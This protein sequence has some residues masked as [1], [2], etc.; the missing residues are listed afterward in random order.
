MVLLLE[1]REFR[2]ANSVYEIVKK[3]KIVPC[4]VDKRETF[5]E[6]LIKRGVIIE[7]NGL[8]KIEQNKLFFDF[9]ESNV[10][11]KIESI[12]KDNSYVTPW[13]KD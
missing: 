12:I 1:L 7:K 8:Y 11:R 6:G 13:Y 9:L 4:S 2:E 5:I 10:G 3:L